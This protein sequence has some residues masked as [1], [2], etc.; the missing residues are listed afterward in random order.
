V[1]TILI[2]GGA[3][4]IGSHLADDAL[5][6]GHKVVI[7][8]DLSTVKRVNV[9]EGAVFHQRNLLEPGLEELLRDEGVDTISHHAAQANVRV[10]I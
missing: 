10:S 7:L 6:R 8:D 9:P 5:A 1:R 2:T 4:F 3:G